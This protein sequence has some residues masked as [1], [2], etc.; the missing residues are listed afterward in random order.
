M[1]LD[2]F[3]VNVGTR[4]QTEGD[5]LPFQVHQG[6]HG[7]QI[8]IVG[9]HKAIVG[10]AGSKSPEALF[11]IVKVLEEVQMVR[12]NIQDHSN[13]RMEREEGII[14]LTGLHHNHV[15]VS[16]AVPRV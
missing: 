12:F 10:N 6:L 5:D 4:I 7:V 2:V 8:I 15:P 3:S 16:D 1:I 14:V 13:G 9:D 11:H